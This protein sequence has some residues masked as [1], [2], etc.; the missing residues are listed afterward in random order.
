M[1]QHDAPPVALCSSQSRTSE[2]TKATCQ[3]RERKAYP[4]AK[5]SSRQEAEEDGAWYAEC[6]QPSATEN[7]SS[8]P[9]LQGRQ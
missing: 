2:N 8:Q 5:Q 3:Q 9:R 1:K 4:E 6:L 7:W